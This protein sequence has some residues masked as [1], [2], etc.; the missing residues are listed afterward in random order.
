ME[1]FQRRTAGKLKVKVK[2][3]KA[4]TLKEFITEKKVRMLT[5]NSKYEAEYAMRHSATE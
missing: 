3:N 2:R 1:D 5:E 4:Q